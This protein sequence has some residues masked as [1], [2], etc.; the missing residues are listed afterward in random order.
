MFFI[1]TKYSN[2]LLVPI[3]EGIRLERLEGSGLEYKIMTGPIEL[4]AYGPSTAEKVMQKIREAI[5]KGLR[6]YYM[7]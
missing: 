5:T 6:L 4:G 1:Q 3:T 2:G 7:P